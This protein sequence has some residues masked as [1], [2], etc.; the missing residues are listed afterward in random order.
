MKALRPKIAKVAGI[1]ILRIFDM[2]ILNTASSLCHAFL[3][4]AVFLGSA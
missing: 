3:T 2:S 1:L 4:L